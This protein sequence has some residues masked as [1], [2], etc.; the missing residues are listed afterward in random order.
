MCV[1]AHKNSKNLWIVGLAVMY[2]LTGISRIRLLSY[3]VAEF[4]Y[5][6]VVGG[7]PWWSSG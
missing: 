4:N 2:T 5:A 7:F 1:T 3:Q 6:W